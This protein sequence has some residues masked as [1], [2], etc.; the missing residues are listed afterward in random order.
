MKTAPKRCVKVLLASLSFG[1]G[2][3]GSTTSV[4]LCWV[5]VGAHR[6]TASVSAS[7]HTPVFLCV[8]SVGKGVLS[9]PH[10]RPLHSQALDMLNSHMNV[11]KSIRAPSKHSGPFLLAW[12]AEVKGNRGG[13]GE[14]A[15]SPHCCEN[16]PSYVA[17]YILFSPFSQNKISSSS[18]SIR[19][20]L[21]IYVN[22][23]LSLLHGP[24]RPLAHL[25]G[26]RCW[27][28]SGLA[29]HRRSG[30]VWQSLFQL[31]AR[32]CSQHAPD[33]NYARQSVISFSLFQA[34]TDSNLKWACFIHSEGLHQCHLGVVC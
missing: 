23:I 33:D 7:A 4:S 21:E 27:W 18:S 11:D 12:E 9:L 2:R 5:C 20:Y 29:A 34:R 3:R 13:R 8:F 1:Q 30:G 14:V 32:V 19:V 28:C 10:E 25:P 31:C 24:K 17:D 16:V 6:D 26:P 22:P 15:K